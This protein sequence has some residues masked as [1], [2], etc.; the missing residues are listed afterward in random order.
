MVAC[1]V[2]ADGSCLGNEPPIGWAFEAWIP[3]EG[4]QLLFRRSGV[5]DS[6]STT[7]AE[8]HAAIEGIA[9]AIHHANATS[10][11]V[12]TDCR[13]LLAIIQGHGR[14]AHRNPAIADLVA[15]YRTFSVPVEWLW[16]RRSQ[17]RANCRVN[18]LARQ[19]VR[20]ARGG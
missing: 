10:V 8:L 1:N 19:A 7:V 5:L 11:V 15:R 4:E 18:A 9:F 20:A 12:H 14:R 2:Y 3:G 6:Q 17:W 13:N 16:E